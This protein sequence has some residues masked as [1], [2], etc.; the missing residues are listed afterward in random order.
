M[1][2]RFLALWLFLPV[3]AWGAI[4]APPT[5]AYT[6][7]FLVATSSV[8]AINKL[9][10][11]QTNAYGFNTD[12]FSVA[13][14]NV[15][16]KPVFQTTNQNLTAWG[17]LST[18][19]MASTNQLATTV[20]A[21]TN[22]LN[23]A[24]LAS[25]TVNS[26]QINSDLDALYRSGG[27]AG[28]AVNFSN[29]LWVSMNGNDATAMK[30]RLDKPWATFS[31]ACYN[32][33]NNETIVVLPGNYTNHFSTN[34]TYAGWN[35]R[36]S[37]LYQLTNV[38]VVG[39]GYPRL[40]QTSQVSGLVIRDCANVS[41][42]GLWFDALRWTDLTRF[43]PH[44]KS[45]TYAACELWW[46]TNVTIEDCW[47]SHG[48]DFAIAPLLV[49]GNTNRTPRTVVRHCRFWDFGSW[50]IT[51]ARYDGAAVVTGNDWTVE[52][53]IIIDCANG[54]EP[55][56][57]LNGGPGVSCQ[58]ARN[59]MYGI[60][61]AGIGSSGAFAQ[62]SAIFDNTIVTP[63]GYTRPSDGSN[64]I[65]TCSGIDLDYLTNVTIRGQT[66]SGFTNAFRFLT[67]NANVSLFDNTVTNCVTRFASDGSTVGIIQDGSIPRSVL[68]FG[69][70]SDGTGLN[71]Q[72]ASLSYNSNWFL[73]GID[74]LVFDT[75]DTSPGALVIGDYAN[76][77]GL[78]FVEDD[79]SGT[80]YETLSLFG[81][82]LGATDPRNLRLNNLYVYGTVYATNGLIVTNKVGIATNA[83]AA[84]LHV[85]NGGDAIIDGDLT[86][87]GTY[88]AASIEAGSL[89]VT[90]N[91]DFGTRLLAGAGGPSNFVSSCQYGESYIAA[92][93]NVNVVHVYGYTSS[94]I[95][96]FTFMITN[97]SG[98]NRGFLVSDNASNKWHW[99][100]NQPA[101]VLVTN[102]TTL[103]VEA[104]MHNT[105][106][107][108]A[109]AYYPCP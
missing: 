86:V 42:K 17:N 56:P 84:A 107:W 78:G 7:G 52:D 6:R 106:I 48:N 20:A 55:Y 70:L 57:W 99:A 24:N 31:N 33:A 61:V 50:M 77:A 94:N 8:D 92:T 109:Y 23:G 38:N 18:N 9:G 3:L 63:L 37:L 16:V 66:I 100:Y 79:W 101:P 15:S 14:S 80:D 10:I 97:L 105:N 68:G 21:S 36:L 34:S 74:A 51:A 25:G 39:I 54:I 19:A 87:N 90:T 1:M 32:V 58:I 103:H 12:Q 95:N 59:Q 2:K 76:L 4:P 49:G 11:S 96:Y 26:N 27:S 85:G 69:L 41:V 91:L 5:T 13:G 88:T 81:L 46:T 83:P 102:G 82:T 71:W 35:E 44:E 64:Q 53:D 40:Y 108:A 89:T 45:S 73:S 75:G 60:L 29:T 65:D 47:F 43:V 62:D 98:S 22:N 72:P 104:R 67:H 28:G 30:G 93:N